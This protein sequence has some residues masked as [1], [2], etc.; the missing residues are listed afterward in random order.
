MTDA[1]TVATASPATAALTGSATPAPAG[2]VAIAKPS[3]AKTSV[4]PA[5]I[6]TGDTL[7]KNVFYLL[8]L[9]GHEISH[10]EDEVIALARKI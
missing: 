7:A 8:G 10:I 1:T 5:D 9:L 4:A 3:A 6:A 2:T